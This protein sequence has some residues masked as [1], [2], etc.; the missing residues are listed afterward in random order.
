LGGLIV[1]V[2]C[3]SFRGL[4]GYRGWLWLHIT[5]GSVLENLW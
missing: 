3:A 1:V 5:T 4:W 2:L